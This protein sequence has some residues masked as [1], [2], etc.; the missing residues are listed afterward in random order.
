MSP[1][2]QLKK[3]QLILIAGLVLSL[4]AVFM[5][6]TYIDQ[7]Q[8]IAEDKAKEKLK[9]IQAN[10][11]AVLVAKKDIP[12]GSSIDSDSFEVLIVPNK[13]VQPGAVTSLDRVAG[14]VTI[15]PISKNEQL[16]QNKLSFQRSS[17]DLSS[18]T[19]AGKR[20]ISISVDNLSS[21]SGMIKAGDYV[22]VITMV[23]VP[24]GQ[25]EDGKQINQLAVLP[26][27]QNVL[28]LA[29]GQNIGAPA[30]QE[31]GRYR[32][33]EEAS[34]QGSS[35]LITLALTPQEANLIA[36]VQEQGKIRLVLR[37]PA[38]AKIEP[39]QAANW[40]TLFQYIFPRQ[41]SPVRQEPP[42]VEIYR[43]LNKEKVPLS[44]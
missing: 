32:K 3:Q 19:P 38:D 39:V 18:V 22:D 26:L 15:A 28:V 35:P 41:E 37:S 40:D 8:I 43:G 42:T 44:K 21:L 6:K 10:Q 30:L 9:V 11:T 2:P 14:M 31:G 24:A 25:S 17:G 12:R 16:T 1:L 33:T 20:A 5:I 4:A 13:F 36:F 23:P 7:Q 34:A 27:F 29:V